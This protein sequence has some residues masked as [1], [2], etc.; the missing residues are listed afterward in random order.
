M[1]PEQFGKLIEAFSAEFARRYLK[2][3]DKK[4]QIIPF[5]LNRP[6]RKVLAVYERALAEGK[7]L[8]FINLK[9]RKEGVSTFWQAVIFHR[10]MTNFNWKAKTVGQDMDAAGNLFEM[11]NTFY[12][13]LP[14][15]IKPQIEHSNEKK[16]S[17]SRLRSSIKIG[18]ADVGEKLG[19]SDTIMGLHLTEVAFW[20]AAKVGLNALINTVPDNLDTLIVIE[21]TANGIGGEFYDR[22][23]DAKAGR[24]SFIPIFLAWFEDEDNTL[25]FSS[26]AEKKQFAKSLTDEEQ[27]LR[28]IYRLTLEQ[29]NWRR[30]AIPNK[31]GNDVKQFRQEFPSNDVEAFIASGRPV[32]DVELCAKKMDSCPKPVAI[33]NLEYTRDEDDLITG[34]EFIANPFGFIKLFEPIETL[35]KTEYR[36]RF[37]AGTDVAEGL[38][39]GD[40]SP[41]RVLDRK[42]MKVC[43]AWHGHIDPDL[44]AKEQHKIAM[45]L[46]NDVYFCTER[47]SIGNTTIIMA[48]KYELKQYYQLNFQKGTEVSS[49]KVGFRT[50]GATK[51]ILIG[52]LNAA[53]RD[54]LFEDHDK[55]FWGEAMTFVKNSH[56]QMQAQDKDKDPA[57]KCF[58]DRVM[59]EALMWHC[60]AWL[61]PLEM[62]PKKLTAKQKFERQLRMA[63]GTEPTEA[64]DW[65][66]DW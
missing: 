64:K 18:S 55:D 33:G 59:A 65:R 11:V 56:G 61:S 62:L 23:Q 57:T 36:H 26:E 38:E 32:F 25:A 42:S 29:L 2:I 39:Q 35:T 24:S 16:I 19:R 15:E 50:T 5:E 28:T 8:R 21:S 34:V 44:L 49:D 63:D 43:L 14:A 37:V 9:A 22:W 41:I 1:T 45:F 52:G 60:H 30:W 54:E 17:F 46:G 27:D 40:Y 51:P 6:Q 66:T 20:R 10:T 53:L 48:G 31:C 4:A 13:E 3:K 58:D 7:P 12:K 47:N